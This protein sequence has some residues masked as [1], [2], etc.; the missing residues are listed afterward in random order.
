MGCRVTAVLLDSAGKIVPNAASPETYGRCVKGELFYYTPA[1]PAD[2]TYA[3]QLDN[4]WLTDLTATLSLSKTLPTVTIAARTDG[5]PFTLTTTG[6]GQNA[7]ATFS[8]GAGEHAVPRTDET[9]RPSPR[10]RS[11]RRSLR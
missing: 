9:A 2:G 1:L 3:V 5:T 4:S 11:H 6:P 7:S 10:P 8:L